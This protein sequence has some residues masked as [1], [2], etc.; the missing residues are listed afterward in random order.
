[1]FG[2]DLKNTDFGV[3]YAAVIGAVIEAE[4]EFCF[5]VD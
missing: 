5:A 1:M 3:A 4:D 2:W